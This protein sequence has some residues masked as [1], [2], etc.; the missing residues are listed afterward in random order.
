VNVLII[1][2]GVDMVEIERIRHALERHGTTFLDR[3]LSKEER[4][5]IEGERLT[6]ARIV[7]FVSGRFAAKEAVAKALGTGIGKIAWSDIHIIRTETG[8]PA[9]LVSGEALK[10]SQT[11]QIKNWHISIS[12]TQTN[13]IAYVIAES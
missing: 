7:E 2:I 3:I 1:G 6:S 10:A 5:L 9:I 8:A 13:A 4:D 12:H 11:R